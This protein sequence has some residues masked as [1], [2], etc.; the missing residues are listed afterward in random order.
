MSGEFPA[1]PS[2]PT[3]SAHPLICSSPCGTKTF[4]TVHCPITS[5]TRSCRLEGR[6]LAEP[7][8]PS[9]EV[10]AA[11]DKPSPAVGAAFPCGWR[12]QGTLQNSG[13]TADIGGDKSHQGLNVA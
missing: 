12:Y 9:P 4:G 8:Q 1:H 13:L 2:I 5:S 6:Y 7:D 11:F 10:G 3:H